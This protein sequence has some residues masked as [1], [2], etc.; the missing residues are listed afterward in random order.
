MK[1][2]PDFLC[3]RLRNSGIEALGAL[4]SPFEKVAIALLEAPWNNRE[5]S[6]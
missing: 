3:I 2:G 1:T 6:P 5:N 4:V